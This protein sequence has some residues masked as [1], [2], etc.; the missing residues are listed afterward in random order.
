MNL[1]IPGDEHLI[2]FQCDIP[3]TE[4]QA[5]NLKAAC[6]LLDA[7]SSEVNWA[8][9]F[10]SGPPPGF[11]DAFPGAKDVPDAVAETAMAFYRAAIRAR[12]KYPNDWLD[13]DESPLGVNYLKVRVGAKPAASPFVFTIGSFQGDAD[14][15]AAG[16][17]VSALQA[18]LDL[19]AMGFSWNSSTSAGAVFCAPGERPEHTE[20]PTAWLLRKRL[21][22][23]M[24]H[25]I[26]EENSQEP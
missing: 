22:W 5:E 15:G 6:G 12:T 11:Q 2:F 7:T 4:E 24:Q 25:D 20:E 17:V 14:L 19:P 3:V 26:N 10:R 9:G 8:A 18:H 16:E 1:A 23:N 13:M 21:S